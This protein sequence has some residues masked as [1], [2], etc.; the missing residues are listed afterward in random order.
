M[1][2]A[3]MLSSLTMNLFV[4]HAE[5]REDD[6]GPAQA[7]PPQVNGS[8]RAPHADAP[9][10]NQPEPYDV[11]LQRRDNEGFGFVILT[12]KNKPP[13]GGES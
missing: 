3:A 12:S 9:A 11:T 7:A 8:P 10:V 13:P 6:G 4:L 1:G 2:L 5:G